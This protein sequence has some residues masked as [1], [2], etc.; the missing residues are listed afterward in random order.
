MSELSGSISLRNAPLRSVISD[1][2]QI[3][4]FGVAIG[5]VMLRASSFA[6]EFIVPV[7]ATLV[8]LYVARIASARGA[9]SLLGISA[10]ALLAVTAFYAIVHEPWALFCVTDPGKCNWGIDLY[11]SYVVG[12]FLLLTAPLLGGLLVG[13]EALRP[14]SIAAQQF[15]NLLWLPAAGV[16]TG[17]VVTVSGWNW[18]LLGTMAFIVIGGYAR[19]TDHRAVARVIAIALIVA[20]LVFLALYGVAT[21][22]GCVN[23]GSCG[24]SIAKIMAHWSGA[25]VL[26]GSIVA[27]ATSMFVRHRP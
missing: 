12:W 1:M 23:Q 21:I 3:G 18:Y 5:A 10:A 13:W 15:A 2:W 27:S 14:G 20:A 7:V 22:L 4:P 25:M 24:W 19:T 17:T 26:A 11:S 16:A 8:F 9:R 6:W